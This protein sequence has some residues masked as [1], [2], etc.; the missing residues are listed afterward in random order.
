MSNV[1][2]V[3]LRIGRGSGAAY[4]CA[5]SQGEEASECEGRRGFRF[6]RTL[7]SGDADSGRRTGKAADT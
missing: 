7:Q 4:S 1:E 6:G 2:K 3:F 5:S